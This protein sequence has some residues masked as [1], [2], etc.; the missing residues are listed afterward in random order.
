MTTFASQIT[1]PMASAISSSASAVTNFQTVATNMAAAN[2]G[3]ITLGNLAT[4]PTA[5]RTNLGDL[6]IRHAAALANF[7]T[8]FAQLN[9]CNNLMIAIGALD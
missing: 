6:R 4:S 8:A 5:W 2:F 9:D 7:T 3:S 1:S